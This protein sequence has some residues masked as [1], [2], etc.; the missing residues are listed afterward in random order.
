MRSIAQED[1]EVL[2]ASAGR[3][4]LAQGGTHLGRRLPAGPGQVVMQGSG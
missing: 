2:S 1:G 3:V 4:V